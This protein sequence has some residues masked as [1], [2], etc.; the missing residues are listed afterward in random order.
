MKMQLSNAST[1]VI[2]PSLITQIEVTNGITV[3]LP[4]EV[5]KITDPELANFGDKVISPQVLTWTGDA[6]RNIPYLRTWDSLGKRKDELVTSEGW[7]NLQE[8]GISQGI[9]AIAYENR[10]GSFSRVHQ[11]LK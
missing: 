2:L 3:Y 6:E 7:R 4:S 10:H 9:V 11:F 5:S 1:I 8:L